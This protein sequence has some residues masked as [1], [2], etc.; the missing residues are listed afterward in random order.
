MEQEH[1]AMLRC[2]KLL[3]VLLLLV[4]GNICKV[5]SQARANGGVPPRIHRD[6]VG[7]IRLTRQAHSIL[8]EEF[9]RIVP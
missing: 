2:T 8:A 4:Q 6:F 9:P 5:R 3:Q 1:Q 7:P